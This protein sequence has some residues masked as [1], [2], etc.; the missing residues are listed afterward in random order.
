VLRAL[1]T[2]HGVSIKSVRAALRYAERELSIDRLLLRQ[3]LK[4]SA[5]EIF[6]DRYGQLLQLS[7]SGQL[8][9]RKLLEAYL[10][11]VEW[12]A[13]FPVRLYPFVSMQLTVGR[14][15]AIDPSIAFG[16]PF[17]ARLSISTAAITERIDAGES[18]NDVAAD[19][20][21][22]PQEVEE[23]VVYERAA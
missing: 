9:M 20:D 12:D 16:R 23:A 17:I 7:K 22:E 13:S 21:L 3:E 8:A 10:E 15:I 11:R 18:I 5:G 4:T 19:Y 2:E 14:P 1:R 6:L